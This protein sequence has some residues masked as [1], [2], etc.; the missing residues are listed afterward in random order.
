MLLNSKIMEYGIELRAVSNEAARFIKPSNSA[1]I[2]PTHIE[3]TII[4]NLFTG[5]TLECCRLACSSHSQ[6]GKA[7]AILQLVAQIFD[8]C[9]FKFIALSQLADCESNISSR[10]LLFVIE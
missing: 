8:S 4:R 3:L 7:L 1:N 10:L 5:Q 9:L 6:E 2:L